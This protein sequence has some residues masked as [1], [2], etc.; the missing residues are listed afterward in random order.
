MAREVLPDHPV[1]LE[2]VRR[3][4]RAAGYARCRIVILLAL[5]PVI[6]S[7]RSNRQTNQGT[8]SSWGS[9]RAR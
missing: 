3:A 2:A 5:S 4:A 9:Q 6:A 7:V 8:A 1:G